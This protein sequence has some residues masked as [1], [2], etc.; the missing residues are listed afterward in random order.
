MI[1]TTTP[2]ACA[3]C[4]GRG[5]HK[6]SCPTLGRAEVFDLIDGRL[7]ELETELVRIVEHERRIEALERRLEARVAALERTCE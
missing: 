6:V 7:V 2:A 1:P 5:W 4:G 3:R